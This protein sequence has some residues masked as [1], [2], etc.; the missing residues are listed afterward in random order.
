MSAPVASVRLDNVYS[1][2]EGTPP[3]P[4]FDVY[5]HTREGDSLVIDDDRFIEGGT[6]N[7]IIE[8]R[9]GNPYLI[10]WRQHDFGND[11]T[12]IIRLDVG[13]VEQ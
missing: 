11:P 7:L 12:M 4:A 3:S 5:V 13:E 1:G 10:Y 6:F 8:N 9:Y 2:E